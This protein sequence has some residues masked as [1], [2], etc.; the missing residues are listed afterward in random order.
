MTNS[1]YRRGYQ[2]ERKAMEELEKEGFFAF[3]TAGSH[4][5]FDVVG[6]GSTEGKLIQ[7]KRSKKNKRSDKEAEE[8]IKEFHKR[9]DTLEG[10]IHKVSYSDYFS[11]E[12]WI[13]V[14]RKGWFKKVIK[15]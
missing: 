15:K 9:L 1:N 10:K 7:L 3:R 8:R 4:G 5:V 13:W 11:T 2:T 6:I 12:L 14:D